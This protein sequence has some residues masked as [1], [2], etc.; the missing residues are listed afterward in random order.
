GKRLGLAHGSILSRVGAST[1]P[2]AVHSGC[3]AEQEPAMTPR[4]P[5]SPSRYLDST[6]GSS[7]DVL[8][9]PAQGQRRFPRSSL[10]IPQAA[11]PCQTKKPA[12][13]RAYVCLGA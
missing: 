5:S 12:V 6:L 2:G 7:A 10:T 13:T 3:A 11:C 9:G 1:N 4:S 8:H